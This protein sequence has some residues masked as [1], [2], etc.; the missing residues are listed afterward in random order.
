MGGEHLTNHVFLFSYQCAGFQRPPVHSLSE[1]RMQA[2]EDNM[3]EW[4]SLLHMRTPLCT[5]LLV[6]SHCDVLKGTT[7]EKKQL[8][9]TV[10]RR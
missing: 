7:E 9:A 5:V 10:E 6:A 3:L 4:V 1:R 8:L 2:V